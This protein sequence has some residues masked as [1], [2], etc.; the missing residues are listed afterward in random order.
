MLETTLATS[1]VAF[2]TWF[3]RLFNFAGNDG[4]S[5]FGLGD[6][7]RLDGCVQG[8]KIAFLGDRADLLGDLPDHQDLLLK[9]VNLFAISL[10]FDPDVVIDE[11]VFDG[12]RFV[13]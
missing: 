4:E 11:P 13:D 5:R 10:R 8:Q 9:P 7:G 12:H 3:E 2:S 6:R 1:P